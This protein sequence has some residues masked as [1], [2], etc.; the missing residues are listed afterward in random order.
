MM[1]L[2]RKIALTC[3]PAW[4][5]INVLMTPVFLFLIL[6]ELIVGVLDAMKR[7]DINWQTWCEPRPLS[8]YRSAKLNEAWKDKRFLNAR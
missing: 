7:I 1:K 3:Y 8:Y 4:I 2:L 5:L 6:L